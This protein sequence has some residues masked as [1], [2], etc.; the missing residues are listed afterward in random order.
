MSLI[1]N[2]TKKAEK[3][4]KVCKSYLTK[5]G[6]VIM[7]EQ[8]DDDQ[9]EEIR[10]KLMIKPVEN[11]DYKFDDKITLIKVFQENANKLYL[12]KMWA[13]EKLGLPRC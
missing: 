3:P 1:K 11:P 10:N 8:F 5:R 6:Y 2:T 7:K 13:I 12:P 9:L 4:T